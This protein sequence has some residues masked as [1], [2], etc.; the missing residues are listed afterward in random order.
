MLM[1]ALCVMSFWVVWFCCLLESEPADDEEEDE[2][3]TSVAVAMPGFIHCFIHF[4]CV[5]MIK[6]VTMAMTMR[7]IERETTTAMIQAAK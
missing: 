6:T 1:T 4:V 5:R 7:M 2:D 3:S